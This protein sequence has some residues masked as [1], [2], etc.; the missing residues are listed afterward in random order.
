VSP[1]TA[2]LSLPDRALCLQTFSHFLIVNKTSSF[3]LSLSLSLSLGEAHALILP[4]RVCITMQKCGDTRATGNSDTILRVLSFSRSCTRTEEEWE[5][6]CP[7]QHHDHS[8]FF[9]FLQKQ[10]VG[11]AHSISLRFR[12]T[13]FRAAQARVLASANTITLPSL[14]AYPQTRVPAPSVP[15]PCAG[16]ATH[17][18]TRPFL[19]IALTPARLFPQVYE[20]RP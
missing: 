8:A 10:K 6:P 15:S 18:L 16:A 19:S 1:D 2:Q 9:L 12:S 13:R 3:S 7:F 20:P 14:L 5:W 17:V 4:L 11:A